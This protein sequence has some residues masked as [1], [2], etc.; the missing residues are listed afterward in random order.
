MKR[1]TACR[2]LLAWACAAGAGAALGERPQSSNLPR[3]TAAQSRA[4]RAWMVAL[5]QDQV[6]GPP[7]P[8]WVHR[9]CAGLVRFAVAESLRRHDEAW[10]RAMGWGP[11]QPRPPEVNLSAEQRSLINTWSLPDGSRSAF[12]NALSLVQSNCHYVGRERSQALPADLLFFD[13]GDDQH[14]MAWTGAW[15]LYHTG[16]EPTPQDNGLRHL[17]WQQLMAWPDTRWRPT[18]DNRNFAGFFRLNFVS[19]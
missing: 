14:L 3:L 19:A 16:S 5:L 10:F 15:V 2:A 9:D 8:R 1:R 12:A 7:S 18:I 6:M 17:R 13:Q 4:F 11:G